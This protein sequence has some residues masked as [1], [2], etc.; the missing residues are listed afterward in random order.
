MQQQQDD[1][2]RQQKP[3]SASVSLSLSLSLALPFLAVALP[4]ARL[5]GPAPGEMLAVHPAAEC[6]QR[7]A[8]RVRGQAGAPP[9]LRK[10]TRRY[11]TIAH[12]PTTFPHLF[13]SSSSS[14][15][16]AAAVRLPART[17]NDTQYCSRAVFYPYTFT[18]TRG[19]ARCPRK[20]PLRLACP[21]HRSTFGRNTTVR[22]VVV[23]E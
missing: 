22:V 7:P 1:D 6:T 5:S 11:N 19:T 10:A 21:P 9:S 15:S 18:S 16:S 17:K 3:L 20:S 2:S 4:D 12:R 13:S 23:V 8:S 14:S